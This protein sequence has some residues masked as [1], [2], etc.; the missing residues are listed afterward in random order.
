[1]TNI[2]DVR[3]SPLGRS[4]LTTIVR[5][6]STTTVRFLY[7]E[8]PFDSFP[9]MR[10][11]HYSPVRQFVHLGRSV[12][13]SLNVRS[14][15][16]IT[17]L[18]LP[19]VQVAPLLNRSLIRMSA[20]TYEP[21][22][23]ADKVCSFCQFKEPINFTARG[24][25]HGYLRPSSSDSHHFPTSIPLH[26]PNII[27]FTLPHCPSPSTTFTFLGSSLPTPHGQ[28]IPIIFILTPYPTT[29]GNTHHYPS[30]TAPT[31]ILRPLSFTHTQS[32]I[33]TLTSRPF[34]RPSSPL[35]PTHHPY[36]SPT[37]SSSLY[38]T[39][40]TDIL[41][42]RFSSP[43][44]FFPL[45]SQ[46]LKLKQ[47]P[48]LFVYLRK[49]AEKRRWEE[50]VV[51]G[52]GLGSGVVT[53]SGYDARLSDG[54]KFGRAWRTKGEDELERRLTTIPAVYYDPRRAVR[55]RRLESVT[56]E[57]LMEGGGAAAYVREPADGDSCPWQRR[58]LRWPESWSGI[59]GGVLWIREGRKPCQ[60]V[61]LEKC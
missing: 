8:L 5:Q 3:L 50:A 31:Q 14:L 6:F 26:Q 47:E 15:V 51:A 12:F 52:S 55:R 28:P 9:C 54:W 37:P 58:G 59:D 11:V 2:T 44:H 42:P 17:P 40:T 33:F 25:T 48:L 16:Q 57:E 29:I 21:M 61:G 35:S 20:D 43:S 41:Q 46:V 13:P 36:S 53:S 19:F 60:I 32:S 10:T 27:T 18:Y 39:V 24:D 30:S 38:L 45:P 4:S 1:M 49:Q 22:K 56:R 7:T 23:A 34:P